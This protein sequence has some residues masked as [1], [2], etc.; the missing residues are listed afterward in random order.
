MV[1]RRGNKIV[2]SE[3]SDERERDGPEMEESN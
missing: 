2:P 1:L 3:G